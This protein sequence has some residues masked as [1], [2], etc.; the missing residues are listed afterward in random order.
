VARLD[1]SEYRRL[2]DDPFRDRA[3]T[4]SPDGRR[5]ATY[6]DRGG[7][8]MEVWTI[9]PDGSGL[10][11][12]SDLDGGGGP[13]VWSPDG[14]RTAISSAGSGTTS[15][16]ESTVGTKIHGTPLP[17]PAEDQGFFV[18]GWSPDGKT[19]LG[20][21][22]RRDGTW[23]AT[24]IYSLVTGRYD[25]FDEGGFR[26]LRWFGDS[27]RV[28]YRDAR[29]ISVLDTVSRKSHLLLAVGGLNVEKGLGLTKDEKWI[30]YSETAAEGDIWL[31][32]LP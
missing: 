32:T 16:L 5:I 30:T 29:G 13:P 15:L 20:S 3:G 9:H 17:R 31:A 18:W 4:W 28:L 1:G 22:F 14:S 12:L 19:L 10:V 8:H 27:R 7:H 6:S 2:T 21:L 26:M 24:A 25:I 23:R 11:Q